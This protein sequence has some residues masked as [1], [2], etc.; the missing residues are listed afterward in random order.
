MSEGLA[1]K[2][3]VSMI[4]TADVLY[5]EC[6]DT[7]RDMGHGHGGYLRFPFRKFHYG[8][9]LLVIYF[10]FT[11]STWCLFNEGGER[12]LLST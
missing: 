10:C 2:G 12:T 3:R 11:K 5:C 8:P 9:W 7:C 1:A 6:V 4:E